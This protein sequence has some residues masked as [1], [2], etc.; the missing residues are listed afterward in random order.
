M[1]SVVMRNG[2]ESTADVM[3][4]LPPAGS[5]ESPYFGV[6]DLLPVPSA[7]CEIPGRGRQASD[8]PPSSVADLVGRWEKELVTTLHGRR[9]YLFGHSLGALFAY[10]LATRLDVAGLLV[11]GARPP[12]NAPRGAMAAAFAA[13]QKD[14]W[15]QSDLQLRSGYQFTGQRLTAPIALFSGKDD[16]IVRPEE[17]TEWPNITTGARLGTFSFPGGHDYYLTDPVLVSKS[18]AQL[19]GRIRTL[20]QATDK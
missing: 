8:T 2:T 18:I 5:V 11:S 6:A 17:M 7:H 13:M 9:L 14:P 1:N 12:G 3:V 15:I 19:M 16:K 4:F 20:S 10:E